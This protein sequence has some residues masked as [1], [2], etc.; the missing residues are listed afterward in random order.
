[1]ACRHDCPTGKRPQTSPKLRNLAPPD[2]VQPSFCLNLDQDVANW[3]ETRPSKGVH[4]DS[5]IL[6][7]PCDCHPLKASGLENLFNQVLKLA[8]L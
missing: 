7:V 6:A 1:M 5:A 2:S 3:P 4:I 8:R